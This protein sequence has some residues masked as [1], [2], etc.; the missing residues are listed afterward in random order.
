MKII[1]FG[2]QNFMDTLKKEFQE[3]DTH[4]Y[5]INH[6]EDKADINLIALRI[7]NITH[8]L[9]DG[10]MYN[11][12]DLYYAVKTIKLLNPNVIIICVMNQERKLICHYLTISELAYIVGTGIEIEHLFQNDFIA[13]N[14]SLI[15]SVKNDKKLQKKFY[16]TGYD[17]T[18]RK[19][20]RGVKNGRKKK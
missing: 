20:K 5:F 3:L 11:D 2:N 7:T 16:K 9:I 15:L 1:V 8:L 6:Y 19:E 14:K 13:F 17:T 4:L 12:V 10:D 18:T